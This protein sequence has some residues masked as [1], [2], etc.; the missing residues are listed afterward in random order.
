MASPR[1]IIAANASGEM[2]RRIGVKRHRSA[3]G[4]PSDFPS[5]RPAYGAA[6]AVLKRGANSGFQGK[7]KLHCAQVSAMASVVTMSA[8][9]M[10]LSSSLAEW[11]AGRPD[12]ARRRARPQP[13]FALDRR[14]ARQARRACHTFRVRVPVRAGRFLSSVVGAFFMVSF[15]ENGWPDGQWPCPSD[16]PLRDGISSRAD[17][18]ECRRTRQASLRRHASPASSTSSSRPAKNRTAAP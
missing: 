17:S 14:R 18:T 7:P 16:R 5:S 4:R 6:R 9:L 13:A 2:V 11:R 8:A 15:V 10:P 3:S 1:A 12:A